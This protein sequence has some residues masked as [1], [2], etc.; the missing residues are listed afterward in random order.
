MT[1]IE[2]QIDTEM[3]LR[4]ID[5]LFK[6]I[7]YSGLVLLERVG[8]DWHGEETVL[9]ALNAIETNLT[10]LRAELLRQAELHD[11]RDRE[12]TRYRTLRQAVI[13]IAKEIQP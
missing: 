3:A 12:L 6:S 8:P 2:N 7:P 10:R 9:E 4:R 13:D 11:E 5:I 1:D